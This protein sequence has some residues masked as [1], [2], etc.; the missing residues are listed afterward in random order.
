[1][2]KILTVGVFD[3]FHYGHLRL[4][5]QAR[6]VA[7]N[8]C[9]IVGVQDGRFIKKFKPNTDIFYSTNVR[10]ELVSAI[11]YVDKVVI[12]TDIAESIKNIDFD[13]FAVGED[14]NNDSFKKAIEWCF[15]NNK[16]VV[17]LKRTKNICST[18]LKKVNK[19]RP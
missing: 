16:K 15:N 10:C 12:Y 4:F 1:M 11:R 19:N 18:K 2:T 17:R 8:P 9:L 13:V 6:A 14:Q 3:Y 5:I 7:N